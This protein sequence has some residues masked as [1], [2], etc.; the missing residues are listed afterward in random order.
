MEH[1]ARKNIRLKD[2][3]YSQ[4]GAYF[5]T[6]CAINRDCIFGNILV[7][8]GLCSCHLSAIGKIIEEEIIG[9]SKRY[10]PLEISK[11]VIM[12][13]HIHLIINILNER[14]EQSPCPTL[15]NIVC[16]LKSITT[17][18]AN[19]MDNRPGRII[20]QYRYHDHIIR[21][22]SEYRQIWQY[23]DENPIQW[24]LDE[25]NPQNNPKEILL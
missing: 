21:D 18:H 6:I 3:D 7:G 5:V 15:G 11:Y 19:F 9:L 14:Q 12:P 25:Y 8:Q 1:P 20:W 23:I 16:S 22:D 2:Y 4:N 24:E 10:R 13:N 17:K